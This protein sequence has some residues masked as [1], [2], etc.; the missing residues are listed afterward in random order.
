MHK[1]VSPLYRGTLVQLL[2]WP[3]D[4]VAVVALVSVLLFDGSMSRYAMCSVALACAAVWWDKSKKKGGWSLNSTATHNFLSQSRP[5]WSS[6][7]GHRMYSP[8][9]FRRNVQW[10]IVAVVWFLR[11]QS[12][13][14]RKFVKKNNNKQIKTAGIDPSYN[15]CVVVCYTCVQCCSWRIQKCKN[16]KN[17][18]F[19]PGVEPGTLSENMYSLGCE[20]HVITTTPFEQDTCSNWS[21]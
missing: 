12:N 2:V 15:D 7:R 16:A 8:S 9:A 3:E 5:S 1:R 21:T 11:A 10:L 14:Q 18:M 6:P 20:R 13:H 19:E 4:A 17:E